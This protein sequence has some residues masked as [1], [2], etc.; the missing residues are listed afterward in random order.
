[1]VPGTLLEAHAAQYAY[2]ESGWVSEAAVG[3]NIVLFFR[4]KKEAV[5]RAKAVHEHGG[6][7]LVFQ[8]KKGPDVGLNKKAEIFLSR[9]IGAE[10]AAGCKGGDPR[11]VIAPGK[12]YAHGKAVVDGDIEV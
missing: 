1:M 3:F 2:A 11:K 6:Y 7:F 5:A 12:T 9:Y 8:D 4:A 10:E